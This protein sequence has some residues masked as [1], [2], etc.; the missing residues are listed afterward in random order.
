MLS[1]VPLRV[2]LASLRSST[3]TAIATATPAVDKFKEGFSRIAMCWRKTLIRNFP[4]EDFSQFFSYEGSQRRNLGSYVTKAKAVTNQVKTTSD[5]YEVDPELVSRYVVRPARPEDCGKILRLIVGMA[6]W[7]GKADQVEITEED[8][9]RDGFGEE[10]LYQCI[11]LEACQDNGVSSIIGYFMFTRSYC[12]WKGRSAIWEDLFI[13]DNFRG[14]GLGSVLFHEA[15]RIVY[16]G[17][18]KYIDAYADFENERAMEWYKMC[19]FENIT[20]KHGY[21]I[22]AITRRSLRNYVENHRPIEKLVK[23]GVLVVSTV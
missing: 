21:N 1:R 2:M 7:E 23:S 9:R 11:L 16:L 8:L 3:A 14:K 6:E 18:C 19:G 12:V 5:P 20:E 10:S 17:G 15:S 13:R 22:I 4:I